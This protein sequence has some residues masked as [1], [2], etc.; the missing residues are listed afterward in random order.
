MTHFSNQLLIRVL[1]KKKY[2]LVLKET[3]KI[4]FYPDSVLP[5]PTSPVGLYV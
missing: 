4:C 2:L 5:P 1:K 3:V